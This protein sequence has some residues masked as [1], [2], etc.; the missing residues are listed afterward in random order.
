MPLRPDDAVLPEWP[1]P[2]SLPLWPLLP[3]PPLPLLPP[4]PLPP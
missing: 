2:W 1:E 4:L 3:P